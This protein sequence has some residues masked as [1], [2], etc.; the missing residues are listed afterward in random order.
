MRC[1][2]RGPR[3]REATAE[4]ICCCHGLV[5]VK[6]RK[7]GLSSLSWAAVYIAVSQARSKFG[8]LGRDGMRLRLTPGV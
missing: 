3:G 2:H 4:V 1:G 7:D 6:W 8:R 5:S